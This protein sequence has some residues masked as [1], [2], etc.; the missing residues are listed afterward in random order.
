MYPLLSLLLPSP[1]IDISIHPCTVNNSGRCA[2]DAGT[3]DLYQRLSDVNIAVDSL[4]ND[5][6]V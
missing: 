4:C 6:L 1:P 3:F 5:P 2:C